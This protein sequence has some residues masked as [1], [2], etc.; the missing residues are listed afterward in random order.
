MRI[1]ILHT[2]TRPKT[3]LYQKSYHPFHN[4]PKVLESHLRIKLKLINYQFEEFSSHSS[5][6]PL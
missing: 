1:P 3:L 5:L 2:C 4:T 6:P